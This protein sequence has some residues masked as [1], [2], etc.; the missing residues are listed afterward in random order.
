MDRNSNAYTF[1]FA[2]IMVLVVGTALAYTAISLQPEQAKN[3]RQEKMQNILATVGIK[4]TREEAPA[5]YEE[6]IEK[7]LV[8]NN[9]GEVL[10]GKEAFNVDL[11]KEL[12]KP[13][14]E[15]VFPLYIANVE[16]RKF[17][18]IPLRGSGLWDAIWGYISLESDVNTI[19]GATFDH[20]G[21]TPG[22]G[23]EITKNYFSQKFVNEKVFDENGNL[24]G[25][26]VVKGYTDAGNKDDNKVDSISGATITSVGVSNMIQERL[27]H[28][29][30]YFKTLENFNVASK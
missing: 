7:E 5:K 12:D 24:V 23:A 17:Y 16:G 28:Y 19:A 27:K 8:L 25:V 2:A 4:T 1:I 22:L 13:A 18:I 11:A 26:S 6:Y 15:Q 14:E 29:L 30:A 21:E 3:V 10:E 20:A 9:Q